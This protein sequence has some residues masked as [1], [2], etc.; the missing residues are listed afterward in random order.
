VTSWLDE[1]TPD[2]RER[3]DAFVEHFRR[4]NTEKIA[5]STAFISLLA[6]S[7][8]DVQF[9]A[10]LGT[11][12]MLDKPILAVAVRGAEIPAKLRAVADEIVQADPATEEGQRA[13]RAA[14]LRIVRS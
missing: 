3:W 9:C 1:L 6:P 4:D 11:A 13:I 8:W 2:E 14:A 12:I 10:E 7:G 5:G